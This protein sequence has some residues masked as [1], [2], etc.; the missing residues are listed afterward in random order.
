MDSRMFQF[1][2]ISRV[3]LASLALGIGGCYIPNGGWTLRSGVDLRTHKKPSVFTE[4]V[5][6]RWDEWNRVAQM[7]SA[8]GTSATEICPPI[9]G[10]PPG[11]VISP[12]ITKADSDDSRVVQTSQVSTSKAPAPK[13]AKPTGAWLFR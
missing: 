5:D 2:A 13:P 3:L 4:L 11:T 9:E 10:L 6:T 12:T 8:Y 7:N 1:R